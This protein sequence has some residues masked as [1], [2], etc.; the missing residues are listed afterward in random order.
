MSESRSRRRAWEDR[1]AAGH[2]AWDRGAVSPA[3]R[4]WLSQGTLPAG[5]VLVPG[6]GHG[7]EILELVHSGRDVTAVDIAAQPVRRLLAALAEAQLHAT[8]V[9]ADL[10]RWAPVQPFDAIYEQ[11]CLC[12]LEPQSWTVYAGRLAE[13]LLPGGILLALFMQTGGQGGPPYHCAL[14]QMRELFPAK[15]WE[16]PDGQ[17]LKVPHPTGMSELGLVLTRRG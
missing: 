14:P 7:H 15:L 4:R 8:V 9:Q 6:C 13:W 2:T 10:L 11:T 12:A 5:R 3:L 17:P 1:Y 16:W